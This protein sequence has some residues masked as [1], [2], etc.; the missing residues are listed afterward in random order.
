MNLGSLNSFG[1]SKTQR[2]MA[3]IFQILVPTGLRF[4]FHF[5]GQKDKWYDDRNDQMKIRQY[6]I[7]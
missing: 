2:L 6:K 3:K 7:S 1:D 5:W 4:F